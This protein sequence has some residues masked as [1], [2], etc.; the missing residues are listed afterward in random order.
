MSFTLLYYSLIIYPKLIPFWSV[1][2][3][4]TDF[5]TPFTLTFFFFPLSVRGPTHRSNSTGLDELWVGWPIEQ[6]TG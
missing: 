5:N 3:R 2:D 1:T 4:W 6:A